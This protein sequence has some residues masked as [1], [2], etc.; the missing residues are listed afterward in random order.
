[1]ADPENVGYTAPVRNLT[2][3]T[4]RGYIPTAGTL[5]ALRS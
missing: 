2:P 4:N 3:T 5:Q 1:M